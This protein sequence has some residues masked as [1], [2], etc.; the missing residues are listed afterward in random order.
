MVSISMSVF[1]HDMVPQVDLVAW[2]ETEGLGGL[3]GLVEPSVVARPLEPRTLLP[4]LMIVCN[5]PVRSSGG[6]ERRSLGWARD[7]GGQW[8]CLSM[9]IGVCWLACVK[10]Q[11]IKK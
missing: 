2:E 3:R 11:G 4:T 6:C 7:C 9:A 5:W 1:F 8:Q 10:K